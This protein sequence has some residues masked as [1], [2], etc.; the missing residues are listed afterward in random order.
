[1]VTS[2]GMRISVAMASYNGAR[3]IEQQLQSII[4]QT[5]QPDEIVICDD[6]SSDETVEIIQNV[7]SN[8]PFPLR[9]LRNESR[10]G[11]TRTFQTAIQ[12]C[13]GDII[14]LCDQDDYW[15]PDKLATLEQAF[16]A[17]D[18]LGLLFTD[19][20]IVD[21]ALEPMGYSLWESVG[22]DRQR[23][24][25]LRSDERFDLILSHSFVTGATVAFRTRWSSLIMPFPTDLPYYIHDRW[26]AVLIAAASRIDFID[27]NLIKYRQHGQQQIGAERLHAVQRFGRRLNDVKSNLEGELRALDEL[28]ARVSERPEFDYSAAFH[29]AVRERRRHL[30]V[31]LAL[32]GGRIARIGPI[33]KELAS[34]R[35][36]R[37]SK[38]VLSAL[39]DLVL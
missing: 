21:D 2:A 31:R 4:G 28:E 29:E 5:R 27:R 8:S 22:F 34:G 15:F 10:Q 38:G 25:R 35:Y 7:G 39:K 37:C 18:R 30:Q 32:S 6:Q 23:Q 19:A 16:E 1:M 20:E 13:T 3:Y 33:A 14:A 24:A 12:Q 9:L 17:D 26:A 11:S 36:R